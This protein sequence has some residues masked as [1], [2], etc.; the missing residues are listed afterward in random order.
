[1]NKKRLKKRDK[2]WKNTS[3]PVE[4]FDALR[5]QREFLG[6]ELCSVCEHVYSREQGTCPHCA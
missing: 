5:L 2:K 3:K 1:M 4:D 6:L